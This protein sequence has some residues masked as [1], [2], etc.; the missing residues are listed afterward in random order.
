M[1]EQITLQPHARDLLLSLIKA[2]RTTHA[3]LF[4]G[5]SGA[6]KLDVACAFAQA[7]VCK[8]QG[9]GRCIDCKRAQLRNHPDIQIIQP[10]GANGYLIDQ[11][12]EVV[13]SATRAPIQAQK[14]VFILENVE[15]LGTSAANAFLK[16]LEEPSPRVVLIL[17]T[18]HQ[19]SVLPTILSR[20]Q[21]V[22]FRT[23]PASEAAG[24]VRQNSGA[25]EL[26]ARIALQACDGS[27]TRAVEFLRSNE[28]LEFR[29]RIVEIMGL[30][31]RADDWDVIQ[32][33]SELVKRVEL[34]LDEVR[35]EQEQE[36]AD[37]ADFLAK[38]AIRQIEARNKRQLTAKTRES[39][40]QLTGIVR[41]WLRDLMALCAGADDVI[42]NSDVLPALQA[43]AERTDVA[44]ASAA[45][46]A[47]DVCDESFTY[48][49]S[50]E[51]CIDSMFLEVRDLLYAPAPVFAARALKIRE[52]RR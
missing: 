3:Y 21:V 24:I 22:P 39:L 4:S 10:A 47:V 29:S 27:L 14:K 17:L 35:A 25:S 48:N 50:P 49:V 28:R 52:V 40:R 46:S 41:S 6:G 26:Q 15:M 23:I 13:T 37:N 43:A 20:C 5:P 8:D 44:R 51:T 45:I 9:C 42:V 19:E 34:P 31:A 33:A 16:T 30:L 2:Q 32:Y 18:S 38:S 1:L 11:I 12:R 7:L 36:L